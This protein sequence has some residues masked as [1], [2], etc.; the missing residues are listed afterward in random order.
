MSSEACHGIA[1]ALVSSM[2]TQPNT[3]S[4]PNADLQPTAA[5][6]RLVYSVYDDE[7]RAARAAQLL[8]EAGFPPADV[9]IG[10]QRNG[11]LRQAHAGRKHVIGYAAL[12]GASL[13][14]ALGNVLVMCSAAGLLAL[15][16]GPLA[17][18]SVLTASVLSLLPLAIPGALLGALVGLLRWKR[19][20]PAFP[21]QALSRGTFVGVEVCQGNMF[22]AELTLSGARSTMMERIQDWRGLAQATLHM[23][24]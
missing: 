10:V 17:G 22:D 13:S 19:T 16:L 21:S 20:D 3:A 6:H 8:V 4:I 1:Y 2:E 5:A 12:V 14:A 24:V 11:E 9:Y 23:S 7:A 18:L 15:P